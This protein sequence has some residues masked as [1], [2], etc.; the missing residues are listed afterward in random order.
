MMRYFARIYL[1]VVAGLTAWMWYIEVTMRNDP[2][3]HM[4]PA[5]LLAVATYPTSAI[6]NLAPGFLPSAVLDY[7]LTGPIAFTVVAVAQAAAL[8]AIS[9]L[10]TYFFDRLAAIRAGDGGQ[11]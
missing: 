11:V 8:F 4:L 10:E 3:D 9:R 5:M 1:V 2:R 6:I 7:W